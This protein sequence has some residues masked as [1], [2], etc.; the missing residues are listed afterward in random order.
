MMKKYVSLVGALMWAGLLLFA[1]C[2]SPEEIKSGAVQTAAGI[3]ESTRQAADGTAK[4]TEG[5]IR[6]P[7]DR[8]EKSIQDTIFL[9]RPEDF[10]P[11]EIACG[12]VFVSYE[13]G[14]ENPE[15]LKLYEEAGE[16]FEY[17]YYA[18]YDFNGDGRLDYIVIHPKSQDSGM[19]KTDVCGGDIWFAE[20][21][22]TFRRAKLPEAA[23]LI[24]GT[25][26]KPE[27][28][29]MVLTHVYHL[30][31]LGL[32][33]YRDDEKQ[34]MVLY[35]YNN[36]YEQVTAV[37]VTEK[38]GDLLIEQTQ[39]QTSYEKGEVVRIEFHKE[40]EN[41]NFYQSFLLNRE[42]F[43]PAP[44]EE[45]FTV[46]DGNNDGMDDILFWEGFGGGS[47]GSWELYYL[48]VWSE[49]EGRYVKTQLPQ[50]FS[51]DY[52]THK[53]YAYWRCGFSHEEY[54]IY[55]LQDGE[56][57]SEKELSLDYEVTG[58]GKA[59]YYEWGKKVEETDLT[60]IY[61]GEAYTLLE[62]KYPEFN[63]WRLG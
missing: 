15:L 35:G 48:F 34:D 7:K 32:L 60:D 1:G 14:R 42:A 11:E 47:G 43:W 6:E 53:L 52:E 4:A 19:Q 5:V 56:Y 16:V 29:V 23:Y 2:G 37:K 9:F 10:L 24:G 27:L 36:G 13:D 51:I 50:C 44:D 63:F 58:E 28:F 45:R 49:K 38:K 12:N 46:W 57:R 18:R 54:T 26:E 3:I 61:D 25:W 39:Y 33:V 21:E 62:K 30:E 55:G 17:Y 41:S 20:K 40:G 8:M 31:R 59:T 22:D